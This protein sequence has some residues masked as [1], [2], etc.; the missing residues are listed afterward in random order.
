M[1]RSLL[2]ERTL[3]S[4]RKRNSLRPWRSSWSVC[5]SMISALIVRTTWA[6]LGIEWSV[7]WFNDYR[8]TALAEQFIATFQVLLVRD[9]TARFVS[10]TGAGRDH[11]HGGYGGRTHSSSVA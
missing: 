3:A 1:S 10:A 5:L 8:T 7:E 4:C 9:C 2:H 6:A 11:V